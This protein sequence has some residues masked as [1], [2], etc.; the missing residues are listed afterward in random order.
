MFK[1]NSKIED[2][3]TRLAV[4]AIFEFLENK[5]DKK[6][7]QTLEIGYSIQKEMGDFSLA[8]F[9]L[10]KSFKSSPENI[11]KELSG[12]IVLKK[13]GILK[14]VNSSGPY[15]NFFVDTSKRAEMILTSS[16]DKKSSRFKKKEKVI[17]TRANV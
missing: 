8:C 10:V 1:I 6:T 14:S 9:P 7:L 15:L 4:Q 17:K 12:G 13:E 16:S 11:A 2:K 5:I 3:F